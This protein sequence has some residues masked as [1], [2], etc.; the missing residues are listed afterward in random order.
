MKYAL[1]SRADLDA[2]DALKDPYGSA[3]T[4]SDT[5][6]E[7]RQFETRKRILEEKGYG[8]MI[9]DAE[10]LVTRFPLIEDFEQRISPTYSDDFGLATAQVSGFQGAAVTHRSMQRMAESADSDEPCWVPSEFISVV[11]LTENYVYSG[12]LTATL[13]M[14]ENIMGAFKFCS[15]NLIGCP[16]PAHRFARL[17]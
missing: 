4:I 2:V 13:T 10:R 1:L 7:R 5:L 14:A 3:K 9:A 15:T 8:R 17:E 6:C 11:A 16:M 12:D